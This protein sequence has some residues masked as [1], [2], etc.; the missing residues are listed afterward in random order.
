MPQGWGARAAKRANGASTG[1]G[2]SQ[3]FG[4][5]PRVANNGR[6]RFIVG[7]EWDRGGFLAPSEFPPA[8][9][10]HLTFVCSAV[11]FNLAHQR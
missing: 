1:P 11:A 8:R 4:L 10:S 3:R 9:S 7:G 6:D 2:Y 5:L